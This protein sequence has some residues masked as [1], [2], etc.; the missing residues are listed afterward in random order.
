MD[1]KYKYYTKEQYLKYGNILETSEEIDA[2]LKRHENAVK[3]NKQQI[4]EYR[5]EWKERINESK[6]YIKS[7]YIINF[8][9]N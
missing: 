3:Q 2:R 9:D 5:K 7:N 1:N 6:Y 8:I 4:E